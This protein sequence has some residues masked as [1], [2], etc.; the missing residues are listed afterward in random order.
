MEGP[1]GQGVYLNTRSQMSLDRKL[2]VKMNQIV[3]I[4]K[5]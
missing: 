3:E 4:D 2:Y 5:I 1:E